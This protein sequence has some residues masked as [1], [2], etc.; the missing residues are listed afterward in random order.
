MGKSL[1]GCSWLDRLLFMS[2]SLGMDGKPMPHEP[3]FSCA[4]V[5]CSLLML[6]RD[7]LCEQHLRRRKCTTRVPCRLRRALLDPIIIHHHHIHNR[8]IIAGHHPL[9]VHRPNLIPSFKAWSRTR[10]VLP[11]RLD[12]PVYHCDRGCLLSLLPCGDCF[13]S[14]V[15]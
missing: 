10:I 11:H 15:Q 8:H 9:P 13:F 4:L 1:L 3:E 7:G 2:F 12:G 6:C 5:L 14:F